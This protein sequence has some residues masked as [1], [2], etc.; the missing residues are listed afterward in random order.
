MTYDQIEPGQEV[1][2]VVP[3]PKFCADGV[4]KDKE[5]VTVAGTERERVYVDTVHGSRR[6]C[7]PSVLEA[8]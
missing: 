5:R 4:V 2:I 3:T 1:R 8:R 6:I 7:A